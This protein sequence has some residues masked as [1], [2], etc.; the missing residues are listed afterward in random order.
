MDVGICE[1]MVDGW[2]NTLDGWVNRLEEQ[3]QSIAA[4]GNSAA[5]TKN[6]LAPGWGRRQRRFDAIACIGVVYRVVTL[7]GS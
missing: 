7:Y 3:L 5:A 6:R 2:E 4:N 1:P